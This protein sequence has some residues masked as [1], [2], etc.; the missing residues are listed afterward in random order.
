MI[1]GSRRAKILLF[2]GVQVN[3]KNAL[4]S[5]IGNRNLL[6]FKHEPRRAKV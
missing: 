2:G 3:F 4:Y 5:S 1:E 6:S